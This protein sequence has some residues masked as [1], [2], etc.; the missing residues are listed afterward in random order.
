MDN[1]PELLKLL[2]DLETPLQAT[3]RGEVHEVTLSDLP[4]LYRK[5]QI[6]AG[7]KNGI[8]AEIGNEVGDRLTFLPE[9]E[10]NF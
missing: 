7:R 4:K 8:E 5:L 10:N 9:E 3:E 6:E 2:Q 1:K